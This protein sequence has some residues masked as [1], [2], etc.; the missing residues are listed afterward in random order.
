MDPGAYEG[1]E[2]AVGR[3]DEGAYISKIEARRCWSLTTELILLPPLTQ[4]C[5]IARIPSKE[6]QD[7][8][9]FGLTLG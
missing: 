1:G 3:A 4:A 7:T 6:P 2:G 5:L 8:C 9:K